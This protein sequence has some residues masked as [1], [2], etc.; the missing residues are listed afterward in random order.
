[1]KRT[2]L[3][4]ILLIFSK[5]QASTVITG[6]I[7]NYNSADKIL[8]T[9]PFDCWYY[10][11]TSKEIIPN[12]EGIFSSALEIPQAQ[13]IFVHLN[14]QKLLIYAEPGK[15]IQFTA[16]ILNV[17]SSVKFSGDLKKENNFRK[18]SG[19]LYSSISPEKID[20]KTATLEE[21]NHH[22]DFSRSEFQKKLREG[23]FSKNFKNLTKADLNYVKHVI[24]WDLIIGDRKALKEDKLAWSNALENTHVNTPIDNEEA[25]N[26]NFYQTVL[27]YFPRYLQI[28]SDKEEINVVVKNIMGKSFEEALKEIKLKGERYWEFKVYTSYFSGKVLEKLLAS[29]IENGVRYG[30]LDYLNETYTYF[31]GNY[32][33]SKY[34]AYIDELMAP[35]LK[36]EDKDPISFETTNAS[37]DTFPEIISHHKG[38]VVLIDLWGTWCGPCK[39]EFKY[40]NELKKRF[41][42]EPVDFIY[43][44]FEY[45]RTEPEKIWKKTANFYNLKG[46]HILANDALKENIELLYGSPD[47]KYFPRYILVDKN[48]KI[49]DLTAANPSSEEL[50]YKQINN[51]LN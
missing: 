16:D 15:K 13:N 28:I 31:T 44:A 18:E 3:I 35:V 6:T 41:K 12:E 24:L 33:E 20:Y 1:M 29:F 8:I 45:N 47:R 38:K 51:L 14:D 50:L 21:I 25:I 32:K 17:T 46:R 7:K 40:S 36:L 49:A 22:V 11:D 37:N 10:K 23:N 4:L 26:S 2:F 30:E 19:L 34:R 9:I 48:G 5:L 42:D 43:I 39:K 27:A